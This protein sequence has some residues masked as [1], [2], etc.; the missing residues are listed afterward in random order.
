MSK[1]YDEKKSMKDLIK[2]IHIALDEPFK[3]ENY[4]EM[5]MSF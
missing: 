5:E 3:E 1:F 4:E 2:M